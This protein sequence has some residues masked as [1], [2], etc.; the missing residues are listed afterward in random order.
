MAKLNDPKRKTLSLADFE[1]Y[2]VW[3]WDDDNENHQP[4]SEAEPS[5]AD[6]GTLFIRARFES[7]RRS[8]DGYL[9]GG[10]TFYAFGLFIGG[11]EIVMNFNLPDL[12]EK[13]LVEMFRLL[14]CQP[15]QF[16]PLRFTSPV[17]FKGGRKIS[18]WL[19]L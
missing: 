3:V 11:R 2:P 10:S 16:F 1:K 13:N 15:F 14:K 18:G 4:I 6:Y 12:I 5:P 7:S 9:I 8:F 19:N 17:H